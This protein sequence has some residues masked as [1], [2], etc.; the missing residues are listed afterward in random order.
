MEHLRYQLL[1]PKIAIKENELSIYLVFSVHIIFQDNQTV[2]VIDRMFF[3][4]LI[5][6]IKLT[7]FFKIVWSMMK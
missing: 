6:V 4:Q 3:I 1:N 2:L 7:E 5:N